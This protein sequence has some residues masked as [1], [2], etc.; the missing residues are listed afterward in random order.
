MVQAGSRNSDGNVPNVN[1][2]DDKLNV[3]WTNAD[4]RD[5]NLRAR[6]EVS[7]LGLLFW[8]LFSLQIYKPAVGHF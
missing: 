5:A 3:N 8:G 6:V 4:N 2:N 1:W 7:G